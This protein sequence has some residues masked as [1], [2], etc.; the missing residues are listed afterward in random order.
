MRSGVLLLD[1]FTIA[2]GMVK[3]RKLQRILEQGKQE[4]VKGKSLSQ[5]FQ[6]S[7][8]I[9]SFFVQMIYIGEEG[10][11]LALAFDHISLFFVEKIEQSISRLLT[12]LQPALL[13]IVALFVGVIMLSILIPM[14]DVS[15][16]VL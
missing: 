6:K 1:A 12:L 5:H 16:L 13:L 2:L 15:N 11:D 10:S 9:P 4:L 8:M 7:A 3:N 14:T